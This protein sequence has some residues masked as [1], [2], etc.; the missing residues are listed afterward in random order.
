MHGFSF[1]DI[2]ILSFVQ[3][4]LSTG[5]LLSPA[6]DVGTRSRWTGSRITEVLLGA[7]STTALSVVASVIAAE[8]WG[9]PA[10]RLE[11]A[12]ALL[13]IF[14]IVVISLRPD[15]TVVGQIF[16][17]SYAVAALSFLAYAALI[18][19]YATRSTA[20]GLTFSVLLILE[21]AALIVWNLC[22]ILA[23]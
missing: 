22:S 17:A 16:Y 5:L 6:R 7:L 10:G 14:S 9:L 21:L 13:V 3:L 1:Y 20:E 19:V 11:T 2:F 12:A 15:C 18:A 4:V 23:A 8:L